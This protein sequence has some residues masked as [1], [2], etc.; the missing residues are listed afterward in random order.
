MNPC[1]I[2]KKNLLKTLNGTSEFHLFKPSGHRGMVLTVLPPKK[3][4]VE[5]W[6]SYAANRI[7]EEM[8]CV[9]GIVNVVK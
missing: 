9:S 7:K 8:F 3:V 2:P 6:D 4:S 1:L 5:P